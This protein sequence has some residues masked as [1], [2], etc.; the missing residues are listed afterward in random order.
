VTR[1][2]VVGSGPAGL[3]AADR[4]TAEDVPTVVFEAGPSIGGLAR[5][6]GL[7]GHAVDLGAHMLTLNDPRIAR[8]WTEL[9]G[10]DYDS[11]RR[12]TRVVFDRWTLAYPY[13]PF[14]A[15]RRLGIRETVRC[16]ASLAAARLGR[17]EDRGDLE[18]WVVRRFGRRGFEL[19]FADYVKK[20]FGVH[21]R[22]IDGAFAPTLLGF[23][24]DGSLARAMWSR[25][26]PRRPE[27]PTSVVR[28]SNGI[29]VLA[30]R[31]AER[32]SARGGEVRCDA[33]VTRLTTTGE[34]ITALELQGG[35]SYDVDFVVSALPLPLTSKLVDAAVD[36]APRR[37]AP[38]LRSVVLVYLLIK[39]ESPFDD[40]WV[41]LAPARFKS[42]RVTNFRAWS[43][44]VD[45]VQGVLSVEF[46]CDRSDALWSAPDE[47]LQELAAD[48]LADAGLLR[49]QSVLDGCVIRLP[50]AFPVPSLGYPDVLGATAEEL[51]RFSN[52]EMTA[53]LG[54]TSIVGVHASLVA[55][56]EAG[57]AA[58][59]AVAAAQ[60]T[61]SAGSACGA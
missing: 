45:R 11:A 37:E 23:Q 57:D 5:S 20:L 18:S 28:P 54:A 26:R 41:F 21:A 34:Q 17:R 40:Q 8:I 53:Q 12:R 38:R 1:V 60:R 24:R 2:A 32:I 6:L 59:R 9:V 52:L 13:D 61:I 14:E 49:R 3:A 16:G 33:S 46:W 48:E 10:A 55:G 15:V 30:E 35:A 43:S 47:D 4:L 42:S 7:W 50:D 31:L 36:A 39:G 19:F 29:G 25:C 58:A 51:A 44:R 56:I 27:G 22:E